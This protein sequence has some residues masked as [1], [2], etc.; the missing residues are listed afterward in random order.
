M[1][2]YVVGGMPLGCCGGD[3]NAI[4]VEVE[5]MVIKIVAER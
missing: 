4:D 3:A 2:V 1:T 5:M